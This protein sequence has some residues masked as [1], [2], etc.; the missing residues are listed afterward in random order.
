VL[1]L[2]RCVEHSTGPSFFLWPVERRA[3]S[4]HCCFSDVLTAPRQSQPPTTPWLRTYRHG[5][6]L[7][8]HSALSFVGSSPTRPRCVSGSGLRR[9]RRVFSEWQSKCGAGCGPQHR[10]HGVG[11][12]YREVYTRP[13][14]AW[15]LSLANLGA[16]EAS[17]SG[18][19]AV[20]VARAA[21]AWRWRGGFSD[22][23]WCTPALWLITKRPPF[24]SRRRPTSKP[25][26][27]HRSDSSGS[28][29]DVPTLAIIGSDVL[30]SR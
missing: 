11:T 9:R 10:G 4:F 16:L 14:S 18:R 12:G 26:G 8:P 20:H 1:A 17:M 21:I 24:T 19:R 3:V 30:R 23:L 28:A 7:C 6:R 27:E 2:R 29:V 22:W 13:V 25:R 5:K 15:R